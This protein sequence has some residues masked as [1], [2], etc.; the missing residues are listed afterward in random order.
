MKLHKRLEDLDV[1]VIPGGEEGHISCLTISFFPN[2]DR[3]WTEITW[4]HAAGCSDKNTWVKLET[5]ILQ[6]CHSTGFRQRATV[7]GWARQRWN[8]RC[9]DSAIP[10]DFTFDKNHMSA[11]LF[12]WDCLPSLLCSIN[13]D[14]QFPEALCPRLSARGADLTWRWGEEKERWKE[15]RGKTGELTV[16]L[17]SPRWLFCWAPRLCRGTVQCPLGCSGEDHSPK[18]TGSPV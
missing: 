15:N 7:P 14:Y 16:P 10:I 9:F 18:E 8:P 6:P 11:Q 17:S 12:Y 1:K 4:K 2:G 3:Q 13:P 5:K